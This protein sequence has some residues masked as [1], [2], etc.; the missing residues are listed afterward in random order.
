VTALLQVAIDL[1]DGSTA[2]ASPEIVEPKISVA[3]N[4]CSSIVF[5]R[6]G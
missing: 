3:I 1:S 2:F 4:P 6:G 5:K